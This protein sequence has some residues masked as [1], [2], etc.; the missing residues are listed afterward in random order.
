MQ[1]CNH[2]VG[3]NERTLA[4]IGVTILDGSPKPCSPEVSQPVAQCRST[5]EGKHCLVRCG[6]RAKHVAKAGGAEEEG[7]YKTGACGCALEAIRTS[8]QGAFMRNEQRCGSIGA[9]CG[10]RNA[11]EA[12]VWA[13]IAI[14]GVKWSVVR[15]GSIASTIRFR[16]CRCMTTCTRFKVN[17]LL[18]EGEGG[19][20]KGKGEGEGERGR[21]QG[22]K[23]E[24]QL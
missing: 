18:W 2:C 12:N 21:E 16:A 9:E 1:K 8:G 3:I 19:M 24:K 13:P 15:L 5:G 17:T 23:A 14:G 11:R 20:G 10:L 7:P 6:K 22:E 4:R